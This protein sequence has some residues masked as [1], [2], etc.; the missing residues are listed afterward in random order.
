VRIS[1]GRS[2]TAF[3]LT[4]IIQGNFNFVTSASS[5]A[6]FVTTAVQLIEDYG[7]DGMYVYHLGLRIYP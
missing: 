3:P 7:F 2:K 4:N 1:I 6:T 5:R